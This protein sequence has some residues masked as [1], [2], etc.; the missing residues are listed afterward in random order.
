MSYTYDAFGGSTVISGSMAATVGQV[1]P[2]RYRGYYWDAESGLYY[3]ESRYYDGEVGRFVNGDGAFGANKD[4]LSN[5]IYA[6]CSNN[7]V[8]FS[9]SNGRCKVLWEQGWQ[10]P[11]PGPNSPKCADNQLK[12]VTISKIDKNGNGYFST[13]VDNGDGSY[14]VTT[15][16]YTNRG[17]ATIDYII[18]GGDYA[19]IVA[20]DVSNPAYDAIRAIGG[21]LILAEAIW[22]AANYINE[23]YMSG[24]TPMG[25]FAELEYHYSLFHNTNND[26]D[27]ERARLCQ[28]GGVTKGKTDYDYNAWVFEWVGGMGVAI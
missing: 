1:N 24:R 6:Y 22:D 26:A 16:V 11:C 4:I 23:D 3:L 21:V 20:L 19:G 10:G 5:N 12:S 28:M 14:D 2:V 27:R 18:E 8:M 13:I 7:S 9:D 15:T 25:L 17:E